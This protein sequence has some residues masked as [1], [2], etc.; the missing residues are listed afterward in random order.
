MTPESKAQWH[1]AE[2][3]PVFDLCVLGQLTVGSLAVSGYASLYLLICLF[4]SSFS[5]QRGINEV[6]LMC[7]PQNGDVVAITWRPPPTHTHTQ[8]GKLSPVSTEAYGSHYS[9]PLF[10]ALINHYQ[11]LTKSSTDYVLSY[12]LSARL[13][14][15]CDC[16]IQTVGLLNTERET[17][18]RCERARERELWAHLQRNKTF[19]SHKQTSTCS[20]SAIVLF[21]NN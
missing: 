17:G 11:D 4:F 8:D 9:A 19:R 3:V 6:D 5:S 20:I 1:Q 21:V 7:F 14:R 2:H 13:S 10:H 18:T 12:I 16:T 15:C